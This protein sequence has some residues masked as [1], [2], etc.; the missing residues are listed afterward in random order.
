MWWIFFSSKILNRIAFLSEIRESRRRSSVVSRQKIEKLICRSLFDTANENSL[1]RGSKS[2]TLVGWHAGTE[3]VKFSIFPLPS[4]NPSYVCWASV[5]T[6][7]FNREL[8]RRSIWAT[9]AIDQVDNGTRE[10]IQ[11]W[12]LYAHS[13][14][15]YFAWDK[16]TPS[17]SNYYSRQVYP[18][19]RKRCT[20]YDCEKIV[21][22]LKPQQV[23]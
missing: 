22:I 7:R 6:A 12:W 11:E 19:S 1:V 3:F 8:D 17:T 23:F 10:F 2:L 4:F 14:F 9:L 18:S 13:S 15:H 21:V 20:F 16:S 5:L